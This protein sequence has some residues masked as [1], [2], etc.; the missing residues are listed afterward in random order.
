ML[1]ENGL[2][3]G[4]LIYKHSLQK[5]AIWYTGMSLERGVRYNAGIKWSLFFP[6]KL[7]FF[8]ERTSRWQARYTEDRSEMVN[9]L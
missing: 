8:Q 6:L 4:D 7:T 9:S 5:S 2:K 3:I 1:G